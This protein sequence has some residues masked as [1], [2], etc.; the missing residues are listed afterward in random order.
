[1]KY[2]KLRIAWTVAWG[3]AC[4]LVVA[5]WVRSCWRSERLCWSYAARDVVYV[6]SFR[7]VIW[8]QDVWY[9]YKPPSEPFYMGGPDSRRESICGQW[10]SYA[11]DLYGRTVSMPYWL[12]AMLA[13]T[14]ACLP[15]IRLPR[16]FSL[17]AL[18]IAISL[19]AVGLGLALFAL[20]N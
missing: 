13:A 4:L 9:P 10:P 2:P 15:W 17:R 16:R 11:A 6:S 7:G 12:L 20:R 8:Y 14:T 3:V 19:V 5:L 1:M 18:L